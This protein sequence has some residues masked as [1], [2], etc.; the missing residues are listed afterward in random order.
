[1]KK[2]NQILNEAKLGTRN[3]AWGLF[4]Q[5]ANRQIKK[6]ADTFM[7]HVEALAKF[8]KIKLEV[9]RDMMDSKVGRHY[10]DSLPDAVLQNPTPLNLIKHP[11]IKKEFQAFKKEYDP[12]E[13]ARSLGISE[14]AKLKKGDFIKNKKGVVGKIDNIS[15]DGEIADVT[16]NKGGGASVPIKSLKLFEEVEVA[17]TDLKTNKQKRKKFKDEKAMAKWLDK[18]DV[19]VNAFLKEAG[20]DN[21]LQEMTD[22]RR[23]AEMQK[24]QKRINDFWDRSKG[25]EAKFTAQINLRTKKMKK[26][27]KVM[28]WADALED[29]N[30][31]NEAEVAFRRLKELGVR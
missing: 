26:I 12:V 1:M 22:R 2:F 10:A 28:I 17:Y 8:L 20:P 6:P 13:F 29:Q 11:W 3:K 23:D 27:E 7:A 24:A 16:W 31:H 19:I 4:G 18:A 15:G 25:D 5:L 30:F 9:A 14:A 21:W